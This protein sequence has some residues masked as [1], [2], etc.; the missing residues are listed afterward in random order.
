YFRRS[1][2]HPSV[3]GSLVRG[4]NVIVVVAGLHG[5]VTTVVHQN[6]R[7]ITAIHRWRKGV[8]CSLADLGAVAVAARAN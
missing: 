3:A 2:L 8:C 7:Y 6:S 5:A 1:L 4:E